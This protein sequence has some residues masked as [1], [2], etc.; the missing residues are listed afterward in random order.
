MSKITNEA[1][2]QM[3]DY[4]NKSGYSNSE[5]PINPK[6]ETSR[7]YWLNYYIDTLRK[8]DCLNHIDFDTRVGTSVEPVQGLRIGAGMVMT[9]ESTRNTEFNRDLKSSVILALK[10]SDV[11]TESNI[12]YCN[13][14]IRY[15]DNFDVDAS[16]TFERPIMFQSDIQFDIWNTCRRI[17]YLLRIFPIES[18]ESDFDYDENLRKLV[19]DFVRCVM[20]RNCDQGHKVF[21]GNYTYNIKETDYLDSELDGIMGKRF[22]DILIRS[23]TDDISH[24]ID[25][26]T[27]ETV[28][29]SKGKIR[30]DHQLQV[31]EYAELEERVTGGNWIDV[32]LLYHGTEAEGAKWHGVYG[33]HGRYNL[34][35]YVVDFNKPLDEVISS[36]VK[37]YQEI[38]SR[39]G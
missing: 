13:D 12:E 38:T 3:A 24:I 25:V 19:E 21:E 26:K 33:R 2:I 39:V 23:T 8:L 6:S 10:N 37:A 35:I 20:V 7:K 5:I 11:L 22:C 28:T 4:L 17:W 34:G 36:I 16:D 32:Y 29:V 30:G 15:L 31:K 27:N 1:I 14:I 9:L 18:D